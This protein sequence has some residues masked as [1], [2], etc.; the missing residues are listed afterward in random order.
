MSRDV[1]VETP[2]IICLILPMR[3]FWKVAL[4]Q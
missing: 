1:K 3:S 2:Q 4:L